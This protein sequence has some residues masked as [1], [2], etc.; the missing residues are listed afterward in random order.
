MGIPMHR[1]V[2]HEPEAVWRPEIILVGGTRTS[3][4]GK[5]VFIKTL[6]S[7]MVKLNCII[8]QAISPYCTIV[9]VCLSMPV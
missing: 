4:E 2:F 9:N 8:S 1:F 7:H 3:A 6:N 5:P